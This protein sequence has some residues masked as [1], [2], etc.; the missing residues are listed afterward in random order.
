MTYQLAWYANQ[1][2]MALYMI[3]FATVLCFQLKTGGG[4][5]A[6]LGLAA[7]RP[8]KIL[9]SGEGPTF[10]KQCYMAGPST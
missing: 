3:I 4:K 9:D 1:I 8:A 10:Q 7:R 2:V 6:L 5:V